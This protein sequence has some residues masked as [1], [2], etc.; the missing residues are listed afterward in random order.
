MDINKIRDDHLQRLISIP[1]NWVEFVPS[2]AGLFLLQNI[3]FVGTGMGEPY[4]EDIRRLLLQTD[5]L[6]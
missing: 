5:D 4:E 2:F 3:T 6:S 1:L